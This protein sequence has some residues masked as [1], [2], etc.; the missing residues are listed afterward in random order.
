[1]RHIFNDTKKDEPQSSTPLLEKRKTGSKREWPSTK[2]ALAFFIFLLLFLSII[3]IGRN[4][5]LRSSAETGNWIPHHGAY[6][7]ILMNHKSAK[8][9][10]PILIAIISFNSVFLLTP[11]DETPAIFSSFLLL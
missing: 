3:A 10:N 4:R 9:S 6:T 11:R 8:K 2:E 1:M 7:S 5:F